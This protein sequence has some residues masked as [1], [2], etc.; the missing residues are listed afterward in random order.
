MKFFKLLLINVF[1]ILLL[2]I[3]LEFVLTHYF[4]ENTNHSRVLSRFIRL[5]EFALPNQTIFV[6][7]SDAMKLYTENLAVKDYKIVVDSNGYIQSTNN[8][9]NPD[10]KIIFLGGSTTECLLMDDSLRF[11]SFVGKMFLEKNK[12][13]NTYN[14]GISGNRTT[15]SLNIL[16]NKVIH[17]DFSHAVLM[18]NI[19]D[20][21]HLSLNNN[22]GQEKIPGRE[23]LVTMTSP[24]VE[25][26]D[27]SF[28]RRVGHITRI[29]KAFQIIYPEIYFRLHAMKKNSLFYHN[30]NGKY[31]DQFK[32]INEIQL[33][34]F[35]RNL[36]TFIEIC[37]IHEIEPI[38]MTQFNRISEK[39]FLNN[40]IF[41]QYLKNVSQSEVTVEEFCKT[42]QLFN[43]AILEIGKNENIL[44]IDL[45]KTV[46]A[47]NKYMYDLVHLTEEGS[48]LVG[49]EI[50]EQLFPMLNTQKVA[51][52]VLSN[53]NENLSQ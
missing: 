33:E 27:L 25:D 45:A 42:Y 4:P 19:N 28:F 41:Q 2:L 32:R 44:T 11:P 22:Y 47:N 8:V 10:Y 6:R 23:N 35:S 1:L 15:H 43:Q 49:T 29:K 39:E 38:L 16:A 14:S 17:G 31:W 20:L 48:R 40:P 36:L 51:S 24:S 5:R 52:D 18:H 50:Y 13:V 30:Q 21:V 26:H 3:P 7:P 37:R 46:P 53:A 12:K 34:L 9:E